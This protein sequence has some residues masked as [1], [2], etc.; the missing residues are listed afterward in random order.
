MSDEICVTCDICLS[1]PPA[2]PPGCTPS[3]C[4][5]SVVKQGWTQDFRRRKRNNSLPSRVPHKCQETVSSDYLHT[6]VYNIFIFCL[7]QC[8]I[9]YIDQPYVGFY[10][11]FSIRKQLLLIMYCECWS[12]IIEIMVV[13]CHYFFFFLISVFEEREPRLFKVRTHHSGFPLAA[14]CI[15]VELRWWREAKMNSSTI[16][17]CYLIS[18]SCWDRCVP[19]KIPQIF[20]LFPKRCWSEESVT[21]SFVLAIFQVNRSPCSLSIICQTS[22]SITSYSEPLTAQSN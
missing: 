14:C 1:A 4:L 9:W 20:S 2:F 6:Y 21:F 11:R 22:Q 3:S 7:A 18:S 19:L 8:I 12:W 13:L 10:A 17:S 5:L 16:T 15:S